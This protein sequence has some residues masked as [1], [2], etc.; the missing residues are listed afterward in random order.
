MRKLMIL[1]LL[2]TQLSCAQI[3]YDADYLFI[4]V[5]IIT[6]ND[7]KVLTNKNI[8]VRDGK[9]IEISSTNPNLINA[10]YNIDLEGKYIMPSLSDAHVH[11][12]KDKNDLEKFLILNLLNGVT[13][14]R[15]MRG[16][17]NHLEWRNQYN[18]KI[19]IYPKLYLSA[20]P[21]SRKYDFNTEQLEEY[22]KKAKEFDFIKILSIKNEI[23]FKD[24]DSLSKINNIQI[25]GHFPNNISDVLLFKSNYTS[26]E[27]LGGLT[28][29]SDSIEGRMQEIKNNKIFIC[30]TLSWYSI[31][32]G[33]Y[34]YEELRNQPGMQYIS[35][36]IIDDWIEK[37]KLYRDKLGYEAYKEEVE[38]ELKKL[39]NK[40]QVIKKLNALDVKMILSPDSSSKYMVAGFGLFGEMKLLKNAE[41][42]NFEILKMT[43][44]NFAD[45][46]N[47][48]YGTIEEGKEA[49][50]IILNDNPLNNLNTLK[51]IEGLFFNSNYLDKNDLDNLSKSILPN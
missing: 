7:D 40:Y 1:L 13:K 24:L 4:N 33:R 47:E 39:D 8:L 6:M 9:I 37:T 10:K 22:V 26:F 38:I 50:F 20:P 15:S 28:E 30:P 45:F 23:L 51:S 34:S 12:P 42:S 19:S 14:L 49:D 43:T 31:G 25:G 48:D 18:T 36:V 27:H 17:W 32:S 16:N 41:L 5:S 2:F 29:L 44:V 3:S 11:L 21:I 35:K 46:F